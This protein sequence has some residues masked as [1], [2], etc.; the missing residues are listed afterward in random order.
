MREQLRVLFLDIDGVVATY[1]SKWELFEQTWGE[2]PSP[3]DDRW[4]EMARMFRNDMEWWPFDLHVL[5][6]L[7]RLYRATGFQLVISSTWRRSFKEMNT[8]VEQ[9]HARRL[10]FPIA[11]RTI[12]APH[13]MHVD[14]ASRGYEIGKWIIDNSNLVESF[15]ILDDSTA[16]IY[17]VFAQLTTA[18]H[19]H[20]IV[21]TD[22]NLG[23]DGDELFDQALLALETPITVDYLNELKKIIS[24]ME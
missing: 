18:P 15:V 20:R 9:L 2:P 1:R 16:D 23:F 7:H 13:K 5:E 11:G 19:V 14:R 21:E 6:N 17:P 4:A 8:M 10:Y 22:Y 24:E 12:T 3:L